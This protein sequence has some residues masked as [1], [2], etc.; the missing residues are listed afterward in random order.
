M[1]SRFEERLASGPVVVGDGGM[2]VLI[3]SAVPRLRCPEEANLKSPESVETLHTSFIRAGAD[4]IETNTF[5]ANRQKLAQFFL[6]DELERINGAGVKLAREAREVSGR[7]GLHRRLDRA[8][9]R[10]PLARGRPARRGLRRAGK[11]PRR[12][13]HRP[14]HG[15]DVL[16]A[17]RAGDRDRGRAQRLLAP[18]RRDADLRRGR[19]DAGRPKGRR[20]SR[21]PASAEPRSD[22]RQPRLGAA[23]GALGARGDELRRRPAARGAAERRPREPLRRTRHLPARDA[24]VL[25]RVRRACPPPRR[26]PDRRL[27]RDDAGRD[28]SDPLRCRGGAR[29][30]RAARRARARAP[31]AGPRRRALRDGAGAE[32]AR[33]RMGHM[34][35]A[36][37]A[38]GRHLRL[39]AR[40]RAHAEG[41]PARSASSTSTTIRWP[42]PARTRSW[43]RSRSSATATWRRSRT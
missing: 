3:T 9:R 12:P 17:R 40:R 13:R 36:R 29:A 32:A 31:G 6:E 20:R 19:R 8:A 42:A 4:L 11:D 26:A 16:R 27:L 38:E 28:R 5:G 10:R 37:S 23:R 1:N 25:R 39:D 18:D 33:G 24:R 35:R 30:G 15:R 34:R 43:L 21:A 14:V 41:A 22:R 7:R 2:G